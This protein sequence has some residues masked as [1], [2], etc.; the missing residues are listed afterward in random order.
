M[1]KGNEKVNISGHGSKPKKSTP[2]S[3]LITDPENRPLLVAKLRDDLM[4]LKKAG[5]FVY[6]RAG[7]SELIDSVE[8]TISAPR[9]DRLL[10]NSGYI[11]NGKE[12]I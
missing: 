5:F 2:Q 11:Y 8:I 10:Y 6:E 1:T 12:V 3:A 4:A 9:E 7:R